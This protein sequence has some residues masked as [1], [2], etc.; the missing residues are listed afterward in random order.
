M[1]EERDDR[2]AR[3]I[4]ALQECPH[5]HRKIVPPYRETEEDRIVLRHLF[6]CKVDHDLGTLI[7]I[8][9]LLGPVSSLIIIIGIRILCRHT[10]KIPA[11]FI[12]HPMCHA[13]EMS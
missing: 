10:I 6:F 11:R 13:V 4:I 1:R 9:L 8:L 3:E 7:V 12:C 2:L 5:G